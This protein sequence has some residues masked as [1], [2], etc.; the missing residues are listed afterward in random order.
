MTAMS[1]ATNSLDAAY[2]EYR[3]HLSG[4]REEKERAA[5]ELDYELDAVKSTSARWS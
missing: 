3:R 5:M 4:S 1:A 2:V